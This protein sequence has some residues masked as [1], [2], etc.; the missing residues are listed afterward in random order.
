MMKILSEQQKDYIEL[1][2]YRLVEY[3]LDKFPD[4]SEELEEL[5]NTFLKQKELERKNL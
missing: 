4:S 3:I 2:I 1:N 5:L